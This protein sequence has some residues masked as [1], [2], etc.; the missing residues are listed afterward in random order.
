M[1]DH[2]SP[3]Q[4]ACEGERLH[5][6]K[7]RCAQFLPATSHRRL[8]SSMNDEHRFMVC[9]PEALKHLPPSSGQFTDLVAKQEACCKRRGGAG[10]AK[11]EAQAAAARAVAAREA[12]QR[13]ADGE[14]RA[15]GLHWHARDIF[16]AAAAEASQQG[17]RA[18]EN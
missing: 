15:V 12:A 11:R 14:R 17:A 13:C 16:S 6:M 8:L 18:C 4:L 7:Q 10:A 5:L 9:L 2:A 1:A 3:V